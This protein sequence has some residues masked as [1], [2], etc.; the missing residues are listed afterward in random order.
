MATK[1]RAKFKC[2]EITRMA[3]TVYGQ[4]GQPEKREGRTI[5]LSP[6]YSDDPNAENRKF[7]EATPS[8]SIELAVI[9]EAGYAPFELDHDYYVDFTHAD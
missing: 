7:W 6:V 4:D 9:N 5:K 3:R 1:V 8:G 2:Y